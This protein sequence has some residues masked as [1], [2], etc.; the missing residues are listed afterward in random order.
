MEEV[1]KLRFGLGFQVETDKGPVDLYSVNADEDVS[2]T[3][4]QSSDYDELLRERNELAA[5]VERLRGVLEKIRVPIIDSFESDPSCLGSGHE[6]D[7]APWPIAEEVIS[8]IS[9]SLVEVPAQSLEAVKREI[10]ILTLD[11]YYA[12]LRCLGMTVPEYIKARLS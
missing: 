2:G 5:Q 11:D 10:A 12:A 7:C 8:D 9:R 4:V 1:K 3:Y 6:S